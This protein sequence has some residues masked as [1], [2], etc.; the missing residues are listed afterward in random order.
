MTA[1][2]PEVNRCRSSANICITVKKYVPQFEIS[3]SQLRS[4]EF[5]NRLEHYEK[6]HQSLGERISALEHELRDLGGENGRLRTENAQLQEKQRDLNRLVNQDPHTGLPIRRLLDQDLASCIQ[7]N[8]TNGSSGRIVVMVLRLDHDYERVKDTRDRG[9][10]LLF[11]TVGRITEV[12]GDHLYQSERV[13]E[14]LVILNRIPNTEAIELIA[15]RI[16]EE[17]GR[18]HEPPAKDVVFG[19]NIGV[20]YQYADKIDRD[21]LVGNAFIALNE[22]RRHAAPFVIYDD[23]MG[24]RFRQIQIIEKELKRSIQD[25]FEE[26]RLLYQPF[27][28]G[29]GRIRGAEALLRW[30]NRILGDVPPSDFVPIAENTGDIR[31]IGQWTL[32]NAC[33]Q[34]RKWHTRQARDVYISINLSPQQFKQHDLVSRIG[35]ILDALRLDGRFLKLELT[36]GAVMEDPEDAI[37][38]MLELRER[39][40][41]ISIDDFGTGYSSLNYLKRLP[42][43]TLKIDKSFIDGLVTNSSNQEIVKAIISL[44]QSLKIETVAEG[45]ETKEQLDFLLHEGCQYIQGYYFARPLPPEDFASILKDG[46]LTAPPHARNGEN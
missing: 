35:G 18:P 24:Q 11:R 44:A 46:S 9:R 3:E 36:E 42:I 2:V 22:A 40:V 29:E 17:V 32:Y 23:H 14:F 39:G 19:C 34:V 33:R 15:E 45:V 26:F 37:L 31:F 16:F 12:V 27:V 43:D 1:A 13:D 38:R 6:I 21:E 5:R 28:D 25:G 30:N 20:A 41:R 8:L 10:A 4:E 7:E